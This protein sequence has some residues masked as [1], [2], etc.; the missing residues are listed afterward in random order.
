MIQVMTIKTVKNE[1]RK[2]R[3]EIDAQ[4]LANYEEI[5]SDK[6]RFDAAKKAARQ[7]AEALD[8]QASMMKKA[9]GPA[10]RRK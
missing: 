9:A 6:A 10:K 5:M 4:T 7:R 3:A 2:W 8:R 1:E